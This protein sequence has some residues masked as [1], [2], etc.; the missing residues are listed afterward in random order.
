MFL[1]T[2]LST[3]FCAALQLVLL[4]YIER[5]GKRYLIL[6]HGA[7]LSQD[8]IL[9]GNP[10]WPVYADLAALELTAIFLPLSQVLGLHAC[11]TT[12]KGLKE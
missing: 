6:I 11:I 7:C 9:L 1:N 4:S 5:R 10:G 8:M 2:K 3:S 12:S